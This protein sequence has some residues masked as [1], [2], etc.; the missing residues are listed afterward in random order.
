MM[1]IGNSLNNT[2]RGG[3]GNDTL[4]GSGSFTQ[5]VLWGGAGS[6][7]FVCNYALKG[8]HDIIMDYTEG[9]VIKIGDWM[10]VNTRG[11]SYVDGAD[12]Y[13][14]F[15]IQGMPSGGILVKNAANKN[16]VVANG[17]GYYSYNRTNIKPAS[18][19]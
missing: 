19:D 3:R 5:N 8:A 6:D 18:D 7:T 11:Y 4:E 9:D 17:E 12:M 15:G 10:W 13:L 14:S 2:I 16:I 1:L